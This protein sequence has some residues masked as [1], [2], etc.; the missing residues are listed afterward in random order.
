MLL[1]SSLVMTV[2]PVDAASEWF[3]RH[4][5][6]DVFAAAALGSIAA[7]PPVASYVLGGE[8]LA[9][10][11][12]QFAVTALIISWIT[13]GVVQL[14]AEMLLLGRRFAVY[15]NITCFFLAIAASFATVY[16][17]KLLGL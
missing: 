3:G 14:P 12:S 6:L 4:D 17:L 8:L 13:V 9:T 15:R 2:F 10:G 11:I 1:L 7:G 5:T 16:T